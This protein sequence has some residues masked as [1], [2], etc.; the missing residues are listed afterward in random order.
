MN[1]PCPSVFNDIFNTKLSVPIELKS[2]LTATV[3]ITPD[4]RSLSATIGQT[5]IIAHIP[6]NGRAEYSPFYNYTTIPS[7]STPLNNN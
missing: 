6:M 1:I 4:E 5:F 7:V 3:D 2:F